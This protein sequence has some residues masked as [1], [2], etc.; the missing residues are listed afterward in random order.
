MDGV[1]HELFQGHSALLRV[2]E[3]F[4]NGLPG[5]ISHE[6]MVPPERRP[7]LWDPFP[8]N[9]KTSAVLVSLFQ[10]NEEL[11]TTLILR[12]SYNGVHSKQIAFPGGK[13]EESD[14]SF[15][16][17]ALREAEEEVGIPVHLPRVLGELTRL[18]IPP[19]K[20]EV[21]PILSTLN[22]IPIWRPDP[23]E[24]DQILEL[25]LSDLRRPNAFQ[26]S[27]RPTSFGPVEVPAFIWKEHI[28][29]GATAM[30]LNELL[31]LID[32]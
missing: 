21:V 2:E 11:H 26:M 24:V 6:R 8:E 18:Y 12:P 9:R 25:P 31:D 14:P 3:R 22:E 4:S 19:S 20:F 10:R 23:T 15:T 17:T 1:K 27:I 7:N 30:I 16:H 32:P 28:I 29:W 13:T 5:L